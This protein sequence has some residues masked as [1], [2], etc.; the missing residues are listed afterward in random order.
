MTNTAITFIAVAITI[1]GLPGNP[2]NT[3]RWHELGTVGQLITARD[4]FQNPLLIP[5][6]GAERELNTV[7]PLLLAVPDSEDDP[8]YAIHDDVILNAWT[9]LNGQVYWTPLVC[10]VEDQ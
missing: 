3:T 1:P 9:T 5:L 2:D 10:P 7:R 8:W 6:C 4:P